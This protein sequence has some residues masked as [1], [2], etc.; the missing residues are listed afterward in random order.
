MRDQFDRI[1][2]HRPDL[3]AEF[4]AHAREYGQKFYP[5]LQ[6]EQG[7]ELEQELHL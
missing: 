1:L 5:E 3:N 2:E 7:K 6:H 4:I